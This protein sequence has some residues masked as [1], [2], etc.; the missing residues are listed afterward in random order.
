MKSIENDSLSLSLLYNRQTS[1]YKGKVS[2]EIGYILK[3][4]F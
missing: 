3:N 1:F 2:P 4:L